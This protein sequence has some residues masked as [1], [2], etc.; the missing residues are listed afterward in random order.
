MFDSVVH[1]TCSVLWS[2]EHVL[3]SI[4]HGLS[5]HPT[6]RPSVSPTVCPSVRPFVRP[7]A[8]KQDS[9][10]SNRKWLDLIIQF[11]ISQKSSIND[12]VISL[13]G[14]DNSNNGIGKLNIF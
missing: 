6:V 5:V 1:R 4:E 2:I 13:N 9:L 7:F 14:L 12:R 3:W 8:R 11:L 10:L